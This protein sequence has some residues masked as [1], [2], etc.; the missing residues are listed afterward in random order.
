MARK[1]RDW[2]SNY[3]DS[4]SDD[5]NIAL[6]AIGSGKMVLVPVFDQNGEIFIQ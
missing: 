6:S 4:D 1:V 2:A 5:P 3:A